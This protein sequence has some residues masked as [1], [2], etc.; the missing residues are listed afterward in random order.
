MVV[1]MMGPVLALVGVGFIHH[2]SLAN[3]VYT[4]LTAFW[5]TLASQ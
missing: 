1:V 4:E 5:R 3:A 2:N